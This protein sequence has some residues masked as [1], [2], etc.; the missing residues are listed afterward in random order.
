[1][2]VHAGSAL[3]DCD[4]LAHPCCWALVFL[5]VLCFR[6]LSFAVGRCPQ[7]PDFAKLNLIEVNVIANAAGVA[8]LTA[9]AWL[10]ATF[11]R[12]ELQRIVQDPSS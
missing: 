6:F 11:R 9:I 10:E 1:M 5:P 3:A 12:K 8:K 2:V 7:I 4:R